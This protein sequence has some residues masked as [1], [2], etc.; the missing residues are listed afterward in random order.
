M[1]LLDDLFMLHEYTFPR[2]LGISEFIVYS[3]YMVIV[4]SLFYK[5]WGLIKKTEYVF[6]FVA[7]V[8]FALS[9]LS[10]VFL[11]QH[12]WEYLLEDGFKLCGIVGWF[13]YFTKTCFKLLHR[14]PK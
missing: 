8:F 14:E 5:F 3:V 10:D 6:L 11:L 13:M 7:C 12:G 9:V 2:Y 4:L 1:L